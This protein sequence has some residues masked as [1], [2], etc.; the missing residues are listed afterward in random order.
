MRLTQKT[1][2]KE[3]SRLQLGLPQLS[4]QP[5]ECKT[6]SWSGGRQQEKTLNANA[7]EPLC[8]SRIAKLALHTYE[9]KQP[10]SALPYYHSTTCILVYR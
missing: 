10:R 9:S 8:L 6:Y 4:H 3:S 1:K 5:S 2:N 7:S